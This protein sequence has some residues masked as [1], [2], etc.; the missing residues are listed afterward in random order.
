MIRF[1]HDIYVCGIAVFGTLM[2]A[3]WPLW[4]T[5]ILVWVAGG[6]PGCR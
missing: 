5:A 1:L 6:F 2:G 3:T 4:L